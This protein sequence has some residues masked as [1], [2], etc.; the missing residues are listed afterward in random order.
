[1]EQGRLS[2]PLDYMCE[3]MCEYLCEYL[4]TKMIRFPLTE[5]THEIEN[6]SSQAL[7]LALR[8]Q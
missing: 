7:R 4:Y 2:G 3:Y 1:M 5:M 8:L 6:M